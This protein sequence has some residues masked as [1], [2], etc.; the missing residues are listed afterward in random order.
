[1]IGIK[2][3]SMMRALRPASLM[4]AAMS[5]PVVWADVEETAGMVVRDASIAGPLDLFDFGPAEDARGHE[6]QHDGKDRKGGHVLVLDR[7]VSGPQRLD[8]AD[9]EPAEHGAGQGADAA[10]H[11][12]SERLNARHEPVGEAH[13]A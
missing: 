5:E 2:S 12:R 6:D 13:H 11:G 7:E 3:P 8:Q 10:E 9:N 4:A 1:M